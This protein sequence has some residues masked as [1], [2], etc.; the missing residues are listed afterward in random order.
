MSS[1][2]VYTLFSGSKG[3][4]TYI[5]GEREHI[6]IDAGMP[7]RSIEASLKSIGISLEDITDIFI[8]HDHS[9]HTRGLEQIC[10]RY[11]PRVHIT[12]PSADVIV[13]GLTPCLAKQASVHPLV[14]TERIGELEISSFAT[15]HDSNASVGYIVKSPDHVLGFATDVGHVTDTVRE[16]LTGADLVIL[17]ANHDIDMLTEGSYPA[18]LKSRI[19]SRYGHL[20]NDDAAELVAFLAEHGAKRFMLA[21]LSE[22]NN[23]PEIA[24]GAVYCALGNI[25]KRGILLSVAHPCSPTRL[26]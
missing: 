15:P 13:T 6:L 20:S 3:N 1:F 9:D 17:E 19:L 14:Y 8:T 11:T 22:Q 2:T 4:C 7:A 24:F 23:E 25:E 16:S 5:A 26:I 18:F 21:H 10:S 12:Q